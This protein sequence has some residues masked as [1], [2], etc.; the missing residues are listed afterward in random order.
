MSS[1]PCAGY[2]TRKN[3]SCNYYLLHSVVTGIEGRLDHGT[4]QEPIRSCDML[5]KI[6]GKPWHHGSQPGFG[7]SVKDKWSSEKEEEELK[8]KS[9]QFR[10]IPVFS[11]KM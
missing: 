3:W 10:S 7:Q 9:V 2:E 5:G 8:N 1:P 4:F 6:W 11:F